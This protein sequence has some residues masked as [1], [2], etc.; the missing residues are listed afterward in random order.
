MIS[1]AYCLECPCGQPLTFY[2]ITSGSG[3]PSG[4]TDGTLTVTVNVFWQ[5]SPSSQ[6]HI[7]SHLQAM[8]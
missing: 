8:S 2:M 4:D 1:K 7:D 3:K 5:A 6:E